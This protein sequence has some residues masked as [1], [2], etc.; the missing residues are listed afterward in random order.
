MLD[1]HNITKM[2]DWGIEI[3]E[4]ERNKW[5]STVI[6]D[7]QKPGIRKSKFIACLPWFNIAETSCFRSEV[8][9]TYPLSQMDE[10]LKA[11]VEVASE[12]KVLLKFHDE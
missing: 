6:E 11:A 3:G 12:G 1:S 4:E 5:I 2:V 8:V 9:K 7:V 10:A